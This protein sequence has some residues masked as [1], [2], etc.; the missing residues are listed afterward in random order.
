MGVQQLLPADRL[1]ALP[2]GEHEAWDFNGF[3]QA[4]REAADA[5]LGLVS[6]R[7]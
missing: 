7:H 3:R 4:L 6:F 2:E 5:G 1:S